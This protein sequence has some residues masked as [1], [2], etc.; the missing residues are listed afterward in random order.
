MLYTQGLD[1][2]CSGR[3]TM[4]WFAFLLITFTPLVYSYEIIVGIGDQ[5]K[6]VIRLEDKKLVGSL[7]S[8]YHCAIES[9][10]VKVEYLSLPDARI[11][12]LLR[13]GSIDIG[14]PLVHQ[15]DRDKYAT[16]TKP[17]SNIPFYLYTLND[18][19][20][21]GELGSFRFS[22]LRASARGSIDNLSEP[23]EFVEVASWDQAL[24]LAK[25]GRTDGAVVPSAVIESIPK[26]KLIGFNKYYFGE[27]VASMYVSKRVINSDLLVRLINSRIP[28]CLSKHKN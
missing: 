10:E 7:G 15:T 5:S 20:L 28:H 4:R 16:F 24:T 14:I 8:I 13:H 25:I 18:I 6:D 9:A 12:Y 3:M 22:V 26:E 21:S 1:I 19:D 27:I 2:N 23:P 11:L 17:I